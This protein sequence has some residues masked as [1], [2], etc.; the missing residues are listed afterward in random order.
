M[1]Q[2]LFVTDKTQVM[3]KELYS[4]FIKSSVQRGRTAKYLN[5]NPAETLPV[6]YKKAKG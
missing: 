2:I 5:H 6:H 1:M 4:I 3:S